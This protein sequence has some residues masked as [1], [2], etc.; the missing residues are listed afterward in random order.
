MP[1]H[2]WNQIQKYMPIYIDRIKYKN[3]CLHRRNK[4]EKY[5]PIHRWKQIQKHMHIHR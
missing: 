2:R 5:M 3:I 1:I 4:I